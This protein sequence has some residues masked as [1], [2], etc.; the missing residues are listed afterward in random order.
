MYSRIQNSKNSDPDPNTVSFQPQLRGYHAERTSARTSVVKKRAEETSYV[1]EAGEKFINS[2]SRVANKR[3][4]ILPLLVICCTTLL[5]GF[6]RMAPTGGKCPLSM[7][8]ILL[9]LHSYWL[10]KAFLLPPSTFST[11]LSSQTL[12]IP[13]YLSR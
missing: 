11:L 9:V 10:L 3:C 1:R 13:P 12:L 5:S 6:P 4:A 7:M 2:G 8:S